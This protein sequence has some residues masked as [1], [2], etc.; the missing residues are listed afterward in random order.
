[1]FSSSNL[2]FIVGASALVLLATTSHTALAQ[3]A[4]LNVT[5]TVEAS[6]TLQGGTL[7]FGNYST[8][9]QEPTD[10]S[11]TITYTCTEGTNVTVVLDDG[12][13]PQGPG[14]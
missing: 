1:M 2:R 11:A 9:A 10:S 12:D 7:A 5:A 4:T 13:Q 14:N 6:C 8:T 3:S